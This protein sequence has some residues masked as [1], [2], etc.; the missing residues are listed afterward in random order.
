MLLLAV[1]FVTSAR[2]L[3]ALPRDIPRP[4]ALPLPTLPDPPPPPPATTSLGARLVIVILN[5]PEL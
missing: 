4:T 5:H 3:S 1:C 2:R